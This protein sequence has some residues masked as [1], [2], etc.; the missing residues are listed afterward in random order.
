MPSMF[1]SKT[2]ND[3]EIQ[4]SPDSPA[5]NVVPDISSVLEFPPIDST[6]K[7]YHP[8]KKYKHSKM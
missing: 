8:N 6:N 2:I 3:L 5:L 1:P 7:S 4:D